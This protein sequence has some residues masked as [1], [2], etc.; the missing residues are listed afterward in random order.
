V[1]H[2]EAQPNELAGLRLLAFDRNVIL[3]ALPVR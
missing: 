3:D 2:N 1:K